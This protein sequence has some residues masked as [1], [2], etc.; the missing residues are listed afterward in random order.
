MEI[1]PFY[2]QESGTWTYL[3]LDAV[4]QAAAIIDPVL[5]YDPVSGKADF[6]FIEQ[7]LEVVKQA[8]CRIEWVLE[9]HAHADHVTAASEIRHRTGARI[10]CG[11]GIENTL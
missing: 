5:V 3:L 6:S 10:A 4:G 9:T 1:T 8:D 7:I 2:E 11:N